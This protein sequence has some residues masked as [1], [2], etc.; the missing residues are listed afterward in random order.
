MIYHILWSLREL[1]TYKLGFYAYE[2]VMGGGTHC[3]LSQLP[4]LYRD[5]PVAIVPGILRAESLA[6]FKAFFN[7]P[8]CRYWNKSQLAEYTLAQ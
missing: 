4:P 3:D 1:F 5:N 2:D 7:D 8:D 6:L